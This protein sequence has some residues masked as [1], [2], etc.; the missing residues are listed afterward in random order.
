MRFKI[1]ILLLAVSISSISFAQQGQASPV[2]LE[3]GFNVGLTSF[4]TDWGIRNDAKSNFSGNMGIG[5]AA[6][7]YV[8]F[9][10]KDPTVT[11]Y[12]SGFAK[13]MILRA[14]VSYFRA[15]IEHHDVRSDV[16]QYMNGTGS[17]LNAGTILEYH[18]NIQPYYIPKKYRKYDPYLSFGVQGSL[19]SPTVNH[20]GLIDAYS[21]V[22]DNDIARVNEDSQFTFSFI[23]G[24]GV[25][26]EIG[27]NSSIVL[28]VHWNYYNTDYIDGL[29]PN[30]EIVANK[31][32]DWTEFFSIGY[33][34]H[35]NK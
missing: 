16:S 10:S 31:N 32:N 17:V 11:P 6:A 14:E 1:F 19:S 28:D 5:V 22:D 7:M 25:K 33:I 24:A 15:K 35:F 21:G 9:F 12:P 27:Y 23:F 34:Y 18:P 29:N 8:K 2:H 13:H 26:R 20:R 3:A 30:P 4:N